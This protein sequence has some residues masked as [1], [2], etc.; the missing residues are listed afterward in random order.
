MWGDRRLN[1]TQL[2]EFTLHV[3]EEFCS[4]T[5]TRMWSSTRLNLTWVLFCWSP[6]SQA[7]IR[8]CTQCSC[9]IP[10]TR[11]YA[12]VTALYLWVCFLRLCACVCVRLIHR[13]VKCRRG[14]VSSCCSVPGSVTV[15]SPSH[16]SCT[17]RRTSPSY[18]PSTN[19]LAPHPCSIALPFTQM[20]GISTIS[21]LVQ[22]VV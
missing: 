3:E 2:N 9:S 5:E 18:P 4:D 10:F 20:A 21:L 1:W 8:L 16:T 15:P 19:Q 12:D 17:T 22:S 14:S 6:G 13:A 7:I 11:P